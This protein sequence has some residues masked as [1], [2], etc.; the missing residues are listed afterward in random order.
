MKTTNIIILGLTAALTA[1]L[2]LTQAHV[3]YAQLQGLTGSTPYVLPVDTQ[4]ET[5]SVL[6]VDN[7]GAVADDV[8]PKIGGGSYRMAGIP[9]GL[10]VLDNDDGGR[11]FTLL[12]NHEL[13]TG[14]GAVRDH[15]GDG[16]FVSR[17]IID[18]NALI[19]TAGD[20]LMKR[21]YGW[22]VARQQSAS[23]PQAF[24]F[25]RYCSADLPE[26]TAFYYEAANIG[27]EARILLNGEEGGTTGWARATIV[28][29]PD[30]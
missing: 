3:V 23:T 10:G 21:V 27:S 15:G 7:T 20:D 26:K 25:N 14:A 16:A 30:A 29:G 8:V 22:D 12:V 19:V 17:W 28:R 4:I 5:L 6:T 9:D 13:A 2:A 1:A 24:S 18:R 11:T